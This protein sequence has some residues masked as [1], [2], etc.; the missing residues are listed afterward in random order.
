MRTDRHIAA[1]ETPEKADTGPDAPSALPLSTFVHIVDSL[2]SALIVF[3]P[4]TLRITYV[5]RRM[6]SL[7]VAFGKR[8]PYAPDEIIGRRIQVFDGGRQGHLLTHPGTLPSQA[9]IELG[10]RTTDV[11]ILAIAGDDGGAGAV[12]LILEPPG[13]DARDGAGGAPHAAGR[14][15]TEIVAG[16]TGR[17]NRGSRR[18][19]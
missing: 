8:L 13:E 15:E 5:N 17:R 7:L 12:V 2:P 11:R 10:G 3:D 9:T 19:H 4:T 18:L 16:T 14:A 6:R 1:D